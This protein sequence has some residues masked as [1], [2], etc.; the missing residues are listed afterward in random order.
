[1]TSTHSVTVPLATSLSPQAQQGHILPNLSTGSLIS[2]GSLCDDNCTA[3]F[4]K[5][6]ITVT[7]HGTPIIHGRRNKVDGLWYIPLPHNTHPTHAHHPLNTTKTPTSRTPRTMYPNTPTCEYMAKNVRDNG[8]NAPP[9]T[10][11]HHHANSTIRCARYK[12]ELANFYHAVAFSPVPST[13][14]RAIH[15]GHFSSWPGLTTSLIT[16]HLTKSIATSKGHLRMQSQNLNST[17]TKSDVNTPAL[18]FAPTQEPSN[19]RTHTAFLTLIDNKEFARSYSDQAGRFPITSS[20]GNKYVFIFYDY[21]ANAI[22]A[23]AIPNRQGSAICE[24]WT[25]T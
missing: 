12:T 6:Q 16:N 8:A 10:S 23:T 24:A 9:S 4:S 5:N 17:K 11:K 14:V 1:M 15:R 25:K 20:R 19:P 13:F 21:D 22:L 2:I 7:K 18:D 3:T